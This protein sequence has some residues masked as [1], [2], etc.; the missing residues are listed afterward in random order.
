MEAS[1][2]K[3][4]N[5]FLRRGW[6]LEGGKGVI[7]IWDMEIAA[8]PLEFPGWSELL[9]SIRRRPQSINNANWATERLEYLP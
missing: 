2:P 6:G 8:R 3:A 4:H 9:A 7:G 1:R 5:A